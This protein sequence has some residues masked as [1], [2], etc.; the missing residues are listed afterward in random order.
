[1][2]RPIAL[3]ITALLV[4]AAFL[5]GCD[6]PATAIAPTPNEAATLDA[7]RQEVVL[8]IVADMTKNAPTATNTVPPTETP[9][10]ASP[11]PE[12]VN[13][14]PPPPPT[15]TNTLAP[16]PAATFTMT[17]TPAEYACTI[18]GVSPA[19][20]TDFKK[21][22]DFDAHFTIN[23]TGQKTIPSDDVDI[24]FTSG[25]AA[26][27]HTSGDIL[28][29]DNSVEPGKTYNVAIDM[30]APD[31]PGNYTSTWTVRGVGRDLCSVTI[32][33]DVVE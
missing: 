14:E 30:M 2:K 7:V 27:L 22:T 32:S 28:D 16:L 21:G 11:T 6:A 5:A 15:A 20:G 9:V 12:P 33:I 10:P 19:A 13:T 24:V 26:K 1:M 31:V 3:H 25:S 23:N 17:P 4:L 29:L 18:S 8:T